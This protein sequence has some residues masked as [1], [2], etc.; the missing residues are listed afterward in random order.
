[1]FGTRAACPLCF[2][3]GD[4]AWH[5]W[6]SYKPV[7]SK[8]E[9]KVWEYLLDTW[10]GKISADSRITTLVLRAYLGIVFIPFCFLEDRWHNRT[11]N[12]IWAGHECWSSC[13]LSDLGNLSSSPR[14]RHL[15][16]KW[17][18]TPCLVGLLEAWTRSSKKCLLQ[19]RHIINGRFNIGSLLPFLWW[20]VMSLLDIL[21]AT[22]RRSPV[23]LICVATT[24]FSILG[25][26]IQAHT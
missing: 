12:K 1:M 20:E 26:Q 17:E 2:G 11:K 23:N 9:M 5:P 4:P 8:N 22:H 24:I 6:V 19:R 25:V 7:R 14:L 13:M 21:K 18:Q 16:C 15:T 3:A 10:I